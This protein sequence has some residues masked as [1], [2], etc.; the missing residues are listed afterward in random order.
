MAIGTYGSEIWELDF[1]GNDLNT[2]KSIKAVD[3][4][5]SKNLKAI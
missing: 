1:T 2:P 5:Y 4:V 3:G